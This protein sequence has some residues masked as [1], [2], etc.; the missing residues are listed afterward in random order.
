MNEKKYDQDRLERIA[1]GA[2]DTNGN[3][4]AF[5]DQINSYAYG[6]ML[7]GDMFVISDSS[8]D[9]GV[10]EVDDLPI[11]MRQKTIDKLQYIHNLSLKD[12]LQ[13]PLWLQKHPLAMDSLTD[14]NSL[15]IIADAQD[16][17]GNNFIIALQL[18]K[19]LGQKD[20]V[21]DVNE[22]A[23]VYGKKNLQFFIENTY[24]AGL[25]IYPNERTADWLLRTGLQ[26]SQPLTSRLCNYSSIDKAPGQQG[27]SRYVVSQYSMTR[28]GDSSNVDE[29]EF[30]T[31][32]KAREFFHSINLRDTWMAEYTSCP[33]PDSMKEVSFLKEILYEVAPGE[34]DDFVCEEYSYEDFVREKDK[35]IDKK[36]IPSL[37]ERCN[38]A[39]EASQGQSNQDVVDK[40]NHDMDVR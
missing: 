7:S 10:Y 15:V 5:K 6:E 24:R 8:H 22:I 28:D 12:I 4:V 40:K 39:K 29:T 16:I 37:T 20:F 9:V 21:I 19:E 14:K 35:E 27:N 11:V 3:L 25:E 26:L 18:D 33:D 23:S 1:R 17:Q 32:E 31:L 30:S 13:L 38:S 34:W 36:A 2:F